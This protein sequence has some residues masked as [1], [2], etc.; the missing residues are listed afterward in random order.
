[1]QNQEARQGP[2]EDFSHHDSFGEEVGQG[3]MNVRHERRHFRT[4]QEFSAELVIMSRHFQFCK[5][6]G[7]IDHRSHDLTGP[8][9]LS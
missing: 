3:A 6:S 1:M 7:E 2:A 5:F 4:G 8:P 9:I